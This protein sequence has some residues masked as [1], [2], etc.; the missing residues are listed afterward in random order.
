MRVFSVALCLGVLL[1]PNG[2]AAAQGAEFEL[3]PFVGGAFFLSDLSPARNG[4]VGAA[5]VNGLI[6]S[7]ETSFAVGGR[8]GLSFGA[9]AVEGTFAYIPTEIAT[10][11]DVTHSADQG[12][13]LLGADV[14]LKK[15]VSPF[16]GVFAAGGVGIKSSS[17]D[18]PFE[19]LQLQ[20][21]GFSSGTDFMFDVGGGIW[22]DLFPSAA[23]RFDVRDYISSF[24]VLGETTTQHDLLITAGLSWRPAG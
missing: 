12:I 1:L 9:V 22:L 15:A 17:A 13:L 10:V 23:L 11:G 7:N 19:E 16:F 2:R 14:L 3:S 24:E 20:P 8:V 4:T 6:Q 5:T 18:D 21:L